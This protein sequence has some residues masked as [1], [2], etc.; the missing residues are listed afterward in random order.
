VLTGAAAFAVGSFFGFIFGIPRTLSSPQPA[1][2]TISGDYKVL[3]NTNLEQ[4]SDWLTKILVGVGLVE[5]S[6]IG[7]ALGN[8]A[9]GL[10][11]SFGGGNTGYPAAMTVIISFLVLGF[12]SAYLFTRLRLEG[13]FSL[14]HAVNEVAAQAEQV[15]KAKEEIVQA[16]AEVVEA[17]QEVVEAKEKIDE[18][19]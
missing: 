1:A 8:L 2:G 9:Q 17:K 18:A 19:T 7:N 5:L 14:A 16:K 3:P 15:E 6:K 4:I 10:S 11:A 13:A 12:I